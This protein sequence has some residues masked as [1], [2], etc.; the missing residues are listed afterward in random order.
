MLKSS[1]RRIAVKGYKDGWIE[2]VRDRRAGETEPSSMETS[3]EPPLR[4]CFSGR[5]D[6]IRHIG[7]ERG[8]TDGNAGKNDD[9][10]PEDLLEEAERVAGL[11]KRDVSL[12]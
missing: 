4:Y 12:L 6:A 9:P 8:W 3:P 1:A 11:S 5:Y 10:V 7:Y 2:G